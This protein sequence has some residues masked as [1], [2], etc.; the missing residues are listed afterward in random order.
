MDI[1][2]IIPVK[3]YQYTDDEVKPF[4]EELISRSNSI[5]GKLSNTDI[6]SLVKNITSFYMKKYAKMV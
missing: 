1:E 3:K 5:K 2:D 6:D 4:V